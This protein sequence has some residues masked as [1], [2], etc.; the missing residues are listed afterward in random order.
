VSQPLTERYGPDDLEIF[1]EEERRRF[2]PP[3]GA[4][5]AWPALA[6]FVAWELLY[7]KEPELYERVIAG[8]RI[9]P[10]VLDRLPSVDRCVEIASGT[11]R[12]TSEL[13]TRC[14]S[15]IAIEPVASFRAM[16]AELAFDN[17]EIRSGFF[18]AIDV[19][20]GWADLTGSCSAFTADP[21]HGGERGL[22]EME[23][24][25]RSGGMIA[26][27]WPS[28]V[29]WLIERGFTCESFEGEMSVEF[30]SLD[31]AVELAGIF[32]PDAVDAIV[33]GGSRIVP[34]E[35]LGINAPRDIAWKVCE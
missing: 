31:D 18:D 4:A 8:E 23:R 10:S 27:V 34:Y 24:V 25:T 13:A 12:L 20:S 2:L 11:G 1:D 16:L 14:R 29:D 19:E 3:F 26:L 28:D 17:V 9:H 35:V 21:R 7:R 22:A 33:S 5:E 30:Q 32:Y 15:I 6:P